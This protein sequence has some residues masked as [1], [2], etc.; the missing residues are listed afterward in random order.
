M[1][2]YWYLIDHFLNFLSHG[3]WIWSV[4]H[5][6]LDEIL[7]YWYLIDYFP[8]SLSHGSCIWSLKHCN[9]P[10]VMAFVFVPIES[11]RL[12]L[13]SVV[14]WSKMHVFSKNRREWN[15]E[16]LDPLYY[17]RMVM[18]KLFYLF[19]LRHSPPSGCRNPAT[20]EIRGLPTGNQADD[21]VVLSDEAQ[22]LYAIFSFL[23]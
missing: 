1:G 15:P 20:F 11:E 10:G 17:Q 5:F 9:I 2:C 12:D 6:F 22:G 3:S 8:D 13:S 21:S 18:P 4:K 16:V 14:T 7:I 23:G 19:E